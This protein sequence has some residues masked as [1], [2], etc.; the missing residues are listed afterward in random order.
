MKS[1]TDIDDALRMNPTAFW[2]PLIFFI[3]L[4][5]QADI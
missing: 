2:D 3:R 4:H 1:L 5:D